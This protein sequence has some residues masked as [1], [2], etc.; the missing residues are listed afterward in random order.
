LYYIPCPHAVAFSWTKYAFK[1]KM[2]YRSLIGKEPSR[3]CCSAVRS[4]PHPS[5]GWG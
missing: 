3:F 5:L 2:E 1:R 4:M